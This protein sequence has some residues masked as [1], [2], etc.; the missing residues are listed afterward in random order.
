MSFNSAKFKANNKKDFK[1]IF[2]FGLA[3]LTSCLVLSGCGVIDSFT[4]EKDNSLKTVVYC[5]PSTY[6]G[7]KNLIEL[8]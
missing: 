4:G 2:R 3:A 7:G 5:K 6:I 8:V 1:K